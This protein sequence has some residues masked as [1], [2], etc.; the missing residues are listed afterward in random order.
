MQQDL[1]KM[2]FMTIED[3]LSLKEF[4]SCLYSQEDLSDKMSE[5]LILELFTFNYNQKVLPRFLWVKV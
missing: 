3:H 5:D 2:I 4:E 1:K